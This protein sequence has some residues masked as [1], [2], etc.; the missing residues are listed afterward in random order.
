[1]TANTRVL[2]IG[3]TG[4]TGSEAVQHLVRR[5]TDVRVATRDPERA[6]TLPALSAAEVVAGDSAQPDTLAAALE[7]VD[8]V[9]YVP[10]TMPGWDEVQSATVALAAAAGVRHFVKMSA[11]GV[12]ADEPSMS[13]SFHWKGEQDVERSG[14]AWTHIRPSSFFQNFLLLD[15]PSLQ[16]ESRFYAPLGDAR[17]AKLDTRDI[18]EVVAAVL[19]EPGHEGATYELTGPAG[20]TY[21]EMAEMLS[22]ALGRRIEYVD[23]TADE[24]EAHL[25]A[26]GWPDWVAAE[27]ASIYGRG[28]YRSGGS[29]FVTTTV[30]DVLGRPPRSFAD[31]ARDHVDVI[32]G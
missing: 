31:F 27:F 25:V 17:V 20:L 18:G 15:V 14:M 28:F 11:I 8:A 4:G 1:M 32:R 2:V 5:G 23:L 6:R 24:Y 21:V 19:T 12:A 13:L 7:G 10:P 30:E 29:S 22:L 26:T 16:A 3:G 9:Y